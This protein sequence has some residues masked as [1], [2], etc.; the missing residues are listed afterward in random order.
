MGRVTRVVD[1]LTEAEV[2]QK[3]KETVGFWRVQKWLVIYNGLV[4]PRPAEEIGK[5]TGLARIFHESLK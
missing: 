4:D 3:I 1:H 5:H 2:R